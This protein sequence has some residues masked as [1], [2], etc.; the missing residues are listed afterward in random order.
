MTNLQVANRTSFKCSSRDY[1]CF[2]LSNKSTALQF[3]TTKNE[4]QYIFDQTSMCDINQFTD[5][6]S[7]TIFAMVQHKN[8]HRK[9]KHI[10]PKT[11]TYNSQIQFTDRHCAA[12]NATFFKWNPVTVWTSTHTYNSQI[13]KGIC[14]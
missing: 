13:S 14:N 6:H 8:R 11:L 5:R 3:H 12:Q 4:S 2:Q 10:I 1:G 9:S 7:K